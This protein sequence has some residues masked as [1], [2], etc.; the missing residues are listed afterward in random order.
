[1]IIYFSGGGVT[2]VWERVNERL[3]LGGSAR[4]LSFAYQRLLFEYCNLVRFT[5]PPHKVKVM[6][7]SGA[8]SAWTKGEQVCREDLANLF[9]RLLAECGDIIDFVLINLDVIPGRK[10][11]DPTREQV[12]SAMKQS[13]TNFDWLNEQFEGLVLPVFHQGEPTKYYDHLTEFYEYVCLSPRNDLHE[14]LRIEWARKFGLRNRERRYHGLAATGLRM[15]E[16]VNWHSV[17]SASWIMSGGYG[18]I[19]WRTPNRLQ[20]VCVSS[21]SANR[22]TFDAHI[23]TLSPVHKDQLVAHIEER[24]FKLDDLQTSDTERYIWNAE[25]WMRL[26]IQF[27]PTQAAGEL[28]D[29]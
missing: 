12:N 10:G 8:F 3:I 16:T 29:A 7:D 13:E 19:F 21:Q 25:E 23:E 24:G 17:D 15:M 18:N 6:V 2:G 9:Q 11:I 1:M 20:T 22:K 5:K 28:F 4:L 26:N 27:R 14:K